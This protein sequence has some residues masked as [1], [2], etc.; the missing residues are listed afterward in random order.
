MDVFTP[1][2]AFLWS[3]IGADT[4]N[5]KGQQTEM[6]ESLKVDKAQNRSVT[7]TIKNL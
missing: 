1:I 6:R 4:E 5:N 2:G 3:F 7:Q